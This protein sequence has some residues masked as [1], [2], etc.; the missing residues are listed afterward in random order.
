MTLATSRPASELGWATMVFS[1]SIGRR[2]R[3][4][5]HRGP[6]CQTAKRIEGT[7]D[8]YEF[9]RRDPPE[10]KPSALS[11]IRK[12]NARVSLSRAIAALSSSHRSLKSEVI[13]ER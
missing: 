1:G 7:G 5:C 9:S 11:L 2:E 13:H 8:G 3:R 6:A 12:L 10:P 4:S